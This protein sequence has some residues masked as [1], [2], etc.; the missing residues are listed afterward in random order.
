LE[1]QFKHTKVYTWNKQALQNEQIRFVVNQGGAR[2]SKTY[3]I[4]QLLITYALTNKRTKINVV[5]KYF[6]TLRDSAYVDFL[7]ILEDYNIYNE[8]QHN[9]T[10]FT[11]KFSNGSEISFFSVDNATK[12]RGRKRNI[13]FIN[14]ANLL[15]YE[16]FFQLNIRTT[17]KIFLDYNPSDNNS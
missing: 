16:D 9:K 2:S 15:D 7:A 6:P 11:Y 12:M 1:L 17:D 8:K 10:L 4:L 5:A 14:E 13:L 3:S